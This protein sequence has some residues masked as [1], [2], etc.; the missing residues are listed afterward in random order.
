ML[1]LVAVP[2]KPVAELQTQ[3]E[4]YVVNLP[5]A[6]HGRK[7]FDAA[8]VSVRKNG[9]NGRKSY[10][11]VWRPVRPLPVSLHIPQRRA[12]ERLAVANA[13]VITHIAVQSE[14]VHMVVICPTGRDS[15][16]AAYLF[17][18]GSE[19]TIQQE[20]NVH[21]ELWDTGFYATESTEP[22]TDAEL[23]IFLEPDHSV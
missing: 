15:V 19:R 11:I 10:A 14:L 4:P 13:C 22:L 5:E 6:R 9:H 16:W 3:T 23:N 2:E 20:F 12:I 21:A 8:T 7:V 18:N 1:T 17:K